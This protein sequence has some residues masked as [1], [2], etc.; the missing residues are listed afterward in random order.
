MADNA[1]NDEDESE[2]AKAMQRCDGTLRIR[3]AKRFQPR[4]DIGAEGEQPGDVTED[5]MSLEDRDN[6]HGMISFQEWWR[7]LTAW[8]AGSRSAYASERADRPRCIR[9][10]SGAPSPAAET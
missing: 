8:L 5:E 9:G 6:R 4:P 1:R 7:R 2:E 3:A 10:P